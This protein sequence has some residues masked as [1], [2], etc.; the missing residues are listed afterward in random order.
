[1]A[2]S[3]YN[4]STV[5]K[6]IKFINTHVGGN[7][8]DDKE[9]FKEQTDL[10][11]QIS[12]SNTTFKNKIKNKNDGFNNYP[13][14]INNRSNITNQL[15]IPDEYDSFIEYL[16]K[17]NLNNINSRVVSNFQY[18]N[19]DSSQVQTNINTNYINLQNNPFIIKNNSNNL[20]ILV[21]SKYIDTFKVGDKITIQ[22]ITPLIRKLSNV[23]FNFQNGSNIVTVNIEYDFTEISKF[24]SVLINFADITNGGLDYFGNIPI[25]ALNQTHS[26]FFVND[27]TQIA[28][29]LPMVFYSTNLS[30]LSSACKTTVYNIGNIPISNINA[31]EPYG[32]LN[33]VSYQTITNVSSTS[34]FIQLPL[35]MNLKNDYIQF[36]GSNVQVGK[37]INYSNNS[38]YEF[39]CNFNYRYTNVASI[40]MISSELSIPNIND[41]NLF[42]NNSNNKFYWTNLIDFNQE[43]NITIPNGLY[44]YDTLLNKM[45]LLLNST[46]R[47]TSDPNIYPFNTF[48][49]N[50]DSRINYFSFRSYNKYILPKCFKNFNKIGDNTYKIIINQINHLLAPL[51]VIEIKNAIDYYVISK[52]DLNTMQT[53]SNVITK[54]LYEIVI[55]NINEIPDVG[56]TGGGNAINIITKNSFSLSFNYPYTVGN[57]L[58]FSNVGLSSSITPYC[59]SDNNYTITN[60]QFYLF[61]N[62]EN[63]TIVDKIN[64]PN[65]SYYLLQCEGLNHTNN[66]FNKNFFYKF[67][68]NGTNTININV[69]YNTFVEMP[70]FFNPPLPYLDCFKLTFTNPEGEPISYKT[71]NYSMTFEIITITNETENTNINTNIAKL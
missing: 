42:I 21:Y 15:L 39:I 71:F 23:N 7:N 68:L 32:K 51:D 29:S 62:I 31:S 16:E 58:K 27:N 41:D 22:G 55:K 69:L 36:G 20:E 30:N 4:K 14:I 57:I 49:L 64:N 3:L 66:P 38:N 52:N 63:A 56:D 9:T 18:L 40:K 28:F 48:L 33:L 1:M 46:K 45:T 47:I 54:D 37:L 19:V 26:I 6:D 10:N 59:N 2:S 67:L 35:K 70:L 8:D 65:F 13:T 34:I 25:N 11:E 24:F 60:D 12:T 50:F 53:V 61:N 17:K 43:Y 5:N 44:N